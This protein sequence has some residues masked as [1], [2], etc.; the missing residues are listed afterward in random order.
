MSN[1]QYPMKILYVTGNPAKLRTAQNFLQGMGIEVEQGIVDITEIQSDSIE[2]IALDKA[3]KSFKILQQPLI[4]NDSGWFFLGLNGF[5]GPFMK[6]INDWFSAENYLDL[7]KNVKDRR[8]ILKQVIVWT[9]GTEYKVFNHD[10]HCFLHKEIR[11]DSPRMSD[12]LIGPTED[13]ISFGEMTEKE[14]FKL[15]GEDA[16]WRELVSFLQSLPKSA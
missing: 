14:D 4:V 13:G 11:G 1:I 3:K 5:P 10:T 15:D 6:Y 16:V 9:D 2:E 7:T 12:N 8:V